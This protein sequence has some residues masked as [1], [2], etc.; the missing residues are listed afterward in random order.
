MNFAG[1]NLVWMVRHPCFAKNF[2]EI[3]EWKCDCLQHERVKGNPFGWLLDFKSC[4][5]QAG[6]ITR[7]L[8]PGVSERLGHIPPTAKQLSTTSRMDEWLQAMAVTMKDA[9]QRDPELGKFLNHTLQRYHHAAQS[10]PASEL[11]TRVSDA[12]LGSSKPI[13]KSTRLF[14]CSL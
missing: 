12:A 11:L 13:L 7:S 14:P 4:A 6:K 3:W 5:R 8:V 9:C 10:S 1:E 2:Q